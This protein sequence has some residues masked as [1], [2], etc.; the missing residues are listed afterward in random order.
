MT[1]TLI[2]AR[3]EKEGAADMGRLVSEKP[4]VSDDF[5]NNVKQTLIDIIS[6]SDNA[7]TLERFRLAYEERRQLP[8]L[9][10]SGESLDPQSSNGLTSAIRSAL[11]MYVPQRGF[12]SPV[13]TGQDQLKSGWRQELVEAAESVIDDDLSIALFETSLRR[14]EVQT[15]EIK[16]EVLKKHLV[17]AIN[18]Y[19]LR[20]HDDT[21]I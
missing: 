11:S 3:A 18:Q 17:G 19:Y 21:Y 1:T 10:E 14:D 4:Y 15:K 16:P 5:K 9:A 7:S 20:R 12:P 2:M 8:W 6:E 13:E